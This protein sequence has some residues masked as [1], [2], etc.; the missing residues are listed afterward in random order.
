MGSKKPTSCNTFPKG[1]SFRFLVDLATPLAQKSEILIFMFCL[2]GSFS[3]AILVKGYQCD[4]FVIGGPFPPFPTF[5]SPIYAAGVRPSHD[6]LCLASIKGRP[7]PA[8]K[9]RVYSGLP[10]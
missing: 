5:T 2:S 6:F 9:A 1:D 4:L 3:T 7:R 8:R 10:S